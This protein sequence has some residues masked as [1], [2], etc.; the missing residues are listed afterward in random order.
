M[1]GKKTQKIDIINERTGEFVTI[2]ADNIY[3]ASPKQETLT[4]IARVGEEIR[5]Y[6][7]GIKQNISIEIDGDKSDL[8]PLGAYDMYVRYDDEYY[9]PYVLG[10][11]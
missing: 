9:Y 2:F 6:E 4:L 8:T 11:S 10:A 7:N 1:L 5:V 3:A